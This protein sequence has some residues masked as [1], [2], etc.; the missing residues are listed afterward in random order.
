M[1]ETAQAPDASAS[2]VV[3]SIDAMGGDRGPSAIVDGMTKS[4]EKAPGLRFIVH[5]DS[6]VLDPLIAR[7]PALAGRCDVRHAEGV[8]SMDDKPS[9]VMRS[10]KGTS[11][12]STIEAVR[13][14]D[15]GQR[16]ATVSPGPERASHLAPE[17]EL[18]DGP[19]HVPDDHKTGMGWDAWY[20]A[21]VPDND[22]QVAEAYDRV[23][24]NLDDVS[25]RRVLARAAYDG[26]CYDEA[27]WHYRWL[28]QRDPSDLDLRLR[29][30][31]TEKRMGYHRVEAKLYREILSRNPHHT[32]ALGGL[33]VALARM[34]RLDEAETVLDELQVAAPTSPTTDET[35]ALI[36]A[37]QGHDKVSLAALDRAFSQRDQL[38]LEMQ[39]ELRRDMA[40]DPALSS[41]RKDTRMR[42]MVHRY[43][44]AAGPRPV[45]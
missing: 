10:G 13:D 4:A 20:L 30:A 37:L 12:W 36:E 41:L 11:M 42:S 39:L 44:G 18:A 26:E 38:S 6:A 28:V 43:L 16:T 34:N 1:V 32:L 8:V 2:E 23:Y 29:L 7:K 22:V 15:A 14:G 25:A 9:Q 24:R 19:A 3:L 45:R 35:V 31:W 40:T 33:A 27:A 17:E 21:E 5:G